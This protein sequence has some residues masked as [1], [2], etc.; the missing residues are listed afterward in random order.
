MTEKFKRTSIESYHN[1]CTLVAVKLM[2]QGRHTD[3]EILTAFRA[4]GYKDDDGMSHYKWTKAAADLGFELET[5]KIPRPKGSKYITYDNDY[6]WWGEV[7]RRV[8]HGKYTLA[9][10]IKDN[11]QGDFFISVVGHALCVRDGRVMDPNCRSSSLS[12]RV[13][14]AK[15]VLN[16]PARL[17]DGRRLEIL[18]LKG[19]WDS[20]AR[21]RRAAAWQWCENYKATHGG[22]AP[23]LEDVLENTPLTKADV[24]WDLKRGRM[25][26]VN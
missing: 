11:P 3:E 19:K 12:R 20:A 8:D 13:T 25:E 5:V 6:A 26:L 18:V 2:A 15:R 7:T 4:N 21:A 10:F 24:N 1:N 23:L 17:A 14:G 16:A 22:Q 9:Q